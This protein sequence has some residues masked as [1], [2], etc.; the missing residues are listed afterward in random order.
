MTTVPPPLS[1]H[2]ANEHGVPIL[3]TGAL[4]ADR[5][6]C[7]VD[8]RSMHVIAETQLQIAACEAACFRRAGDRREAAPKVPQLCEE[9]LP[10]RL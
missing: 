4:F 6:G 5:G 10:Q 8:L 3:R 2:I 1:P 9:N 7:G